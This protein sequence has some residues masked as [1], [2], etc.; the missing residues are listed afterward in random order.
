V[1]EEGQVFEFK[2]NALIHFCVRVTERTFSVST[3]QKQGGPPA[4]TWVLRFDNVAEARV[5]ERIGA[6]ARTVAVFLKPRHGELAMFSWAASP[7][8]QGKIF[9]AAAVATLRALAA[10]KPELQVLY[11]PLLRRAY[12]TGATIMAALAI[13]LA[14]PP[15]GQPLTLLYAAPSAVLLLLTLASVLRSGVFA[16]RRRLSITEAADLM[17]KH[18]AEL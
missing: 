18:G 16:K 6:N 14:I 12:F 17:A 11:G 13:Y 4:R 1:N 7:K 15:N 10:Q 5:H 9:Y 3:H 8:P 2:G